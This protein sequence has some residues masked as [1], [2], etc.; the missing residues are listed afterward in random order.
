MKIKHG[1]PR[2]PVGKRERI[3]THGDATPAT[4][5]STQVNDAGAL[6]PV[7]FSDEQPPETGKIRK[8]NSSKVPYPPKSDPTNPLVILVSPENACMKLLDSN[9][10]SNPNNGNRVSGR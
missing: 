4:P 7:V 9:N 5:E 8:I 6:A 1:Q 3:R 10:L 2:V